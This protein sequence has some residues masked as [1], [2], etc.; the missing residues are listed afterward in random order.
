MYIADNT[1]K[2]LLNNVYF[3]WGSGKTTTANALA[4]K[5]GFVVYHT[6][7]SRSWHFNNTHP[8]Y[9]PAMCRDVP[10]FWA[11]EKE[12]ALAWEHA[13]VKEMTP[14]IVTDLIILSVQH[15]KI[16]CEGDIDIDTVIP[17]VT[18]AVTISNHGKRYDFFDRPE[19]RHML[20]EIKNR[21]DINDDE[22]Q[23][24]IDNAYH[25]LSPE[26]ED[27]SIPRETKLYG[28]KEIIRDET[29]SVE[30]VVKMIEEYWKL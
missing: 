14:M 3:I 22:K 12:D 7:N 13:I 29:T 19:Q 25:I 8:D 18:N 17:V 23:K 15:E 5:H 24:L 20:E 11:L 2:N 26:P 30:D 28:V 10:D 1:I 21:T 16:I 4:E 27:I 6:D 9:Q